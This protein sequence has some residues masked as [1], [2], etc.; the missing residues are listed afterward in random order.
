MLTAAQ[1]YSLDLMGI[2]RWNALEE[3]QHFSFYRPY[4][5]W[6]TTVPAHTEISNKASSTNQGKSVFEQAIISPPTSGFDRSSSPP[7]SAQTAPPQNQT[8]SNLRAELGATP[9]V[10]V[11]DLQPIEELAVA[12]ELPETSAEIELPQQMQCCAFVAEDR[13]LILSDIPPAFTDQIEVEQLAVK[14]SQA[15]LKHSITQ[16]RMGQFDWPGQL[17]NVDFIHRHD[18][19]LGAFES[20]VNAQL[21]TAPEKTN[22]EGYSIQQDSNLLVVL[23]GQNM[24]KFSPQIKQMLNP[25]SAKFVEIVSL[26]ELYR[27]PEY[28]AEA[29]Q[30]LQGLL[31]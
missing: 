31:R 12:I 14:M 22:L 4:S 21:T 25:Y 6:L 15:L 3:S 16:W 23:A 5:P 30:T 28:K 2:T 27:I 17:T 19:M 20:F 26:P 24:Q 13:L 9:E 10:V 7:K 8:V 11:E 1:A 29:W 18:W